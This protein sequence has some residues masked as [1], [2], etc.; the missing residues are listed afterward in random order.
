M[1]FSNRLRAFAIRLN[2]AYSR[3]RHWIVWLEVIGSQDRA[4]RTQVFVRLALWKL[5]LKELTAPV[6]IFSVAPAIFLVG[7]KRSSRKGGFSLAMVASIHRIDD[8]LMS[9]LLVG[10]VETAWEVTANHN[11]TGCRLTRSYL[12]F[13]MM[14]Y[15]FTQSE[16]LGLLELRCVYCTV[17]REKIQGLASQ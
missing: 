12:C 2:C 13:S 10:R 11:C 15:L 8:R 1:I 5:W 17:F 4:E 16:F 7:I 9:S 14:F 3:I 6:N